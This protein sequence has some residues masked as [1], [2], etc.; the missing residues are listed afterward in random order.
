MSAFKSISLQ[1]NNF[2]FH[3]NAG[4]NANSDGTFAN[5]IDGEEEGILCLS[6]ILLKFYKVVTA[7][8]KVV[9]AAKP[10]ALLDSD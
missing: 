1:L 8:K 9:L 7:C 10:L 5:W 4:L 2:T 6:A 3:T